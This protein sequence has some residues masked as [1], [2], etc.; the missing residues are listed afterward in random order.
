MQNNCWLFF[1]LWPYILL[2]TVH[3]VAI[4]L[5]ASSLCMLPDTEENSKCIRQGIMYKTRALIFSKYL[6]ICTIYS[7]VQVL[8]LWSI[9]CLLNFFIILLLLFELDGLL[10]N[11]VSGWRQIVISE[12]L[13]YSRTSVIV[14]S[15][16]TWTL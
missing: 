12:S 11:L 7:T 14:T 4:Y 3:N 16:L 10:L 8:I 2:V 9:S 5:S 15:L 6:C 13:Y 1:L